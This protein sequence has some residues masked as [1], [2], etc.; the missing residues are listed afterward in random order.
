MSFLTHS[1]PYSRTSLLAQLKCI[2]DPAVQSGELYGP[3]GLGGLPVQM[4]L[5]PP[6]VLVE[7]DA[8][9]KLWAACESALGA[10]SL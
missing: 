7:D 5:A 8:K 2:C 10:W 1:L 6:R 9:A 4:P 3:P